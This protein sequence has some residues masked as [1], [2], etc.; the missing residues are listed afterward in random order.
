MKL[1]LL[2]STPN[3][4]KVVACAAKLCYSSSTIL[5]LIDISDDKVESFIERFMNL[6]H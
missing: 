6:G 2:E 5:D 1:M 4:E 3:P